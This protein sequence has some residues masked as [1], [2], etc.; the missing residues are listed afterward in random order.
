M[1]RILL[2]NVWQLGLLTGGLLIADVVTMKDGQQVSGL[3]ESGNTQELHIKVGDRQQTIDIHQ[4]AAIQFGISSTAAPSPP[5]AP[6]SAP[7][8]PEPAPAQADSLIL[9]AGQ[10]V[11]GR[12]WSIDATDVH[13]LVSNQF[14]HVPRSEVSALTLGGAAL[15]SPPAPSTPPPPTP[16][17]PP[18][19]ATQ[20][21][22][23]PTPVR[24][25]TSS[26]PRPP[27]LTRPPANAPPT[28]SRGVSQPEEIGAVYFWNGKDLTPLERN[29]AVA[30]GRD[31]TQYW[32]MPGAQSRV[33]LKEADALV[34]ILR[35]ARGVNPAGYSLF[36]L[37]SVDGTR[38]TQAEP[39]RR[40]GLV[41]WPFKIEVN[42]DS[43]YTTYALTVRSLPAGEYSFS[44]SSS[45]DG[46][47]FGV[48]PADQ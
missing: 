37:A 16:A 33:R 4:V 46:Y 36:S 34:F 12:L 9:K 21:A 19:G 13:F 47:C 2:L 42:D 25:S 18:A 14:Q 31:S 40:G 35:L 43:G 22:R 1:K 39:G 15:P 3:V 8:A 20:P 41:T 5:T 6:G 23:P 29:Q 28:P 26:P 7:R 27:T 11:A 30:R 24:A 45:N 10:P 48:D 38:R 44:P 17:Q 32:E